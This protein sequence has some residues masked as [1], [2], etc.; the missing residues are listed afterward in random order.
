MMSV[1]ATDVHVAIFAS[2]TTGKLEAQ[3]NEVLE[4][5]PGE[6]VG[7]QYDHDHH[8]YRDGEVVHYFTAMIAYT[9]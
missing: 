6:L 1:K 4:E 2:D 7:I 9:R 3:I 8:V 5:I